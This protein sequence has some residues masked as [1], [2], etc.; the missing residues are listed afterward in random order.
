MVNHFRMSR[1]MVGIGHSVDGTQ[2]YSMQIKKSADGSRINLALVHP[3]L[4][5]Q[6]LLIEPMI[7][8][9]VAGPIMPGNPSTVFLSAN[10]RDSSSSRKEAK[11]AFRRMYKN[12]DLWILDLWIEYGLRDLPPTL[13]VALTT[14]KLQ[15]VSSYYRPRFRRKL[16]DLDPNIVDT[17][18]FYRAEAVW[19]FKNMHLVRPEMLFIFG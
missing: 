11:N 3:R 5:M 1:P 16:P 2:L 15:E 17:L 7:E 4:L 8:P 6:L 19:M 10:R 18:P 14:T 13:Q 12:W 9:L